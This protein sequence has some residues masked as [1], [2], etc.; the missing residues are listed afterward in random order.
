M[1]DLIVRGGRLQR[2][3]ALCLALLAACPL[4]APFSTL[5]L[6]A[7][8]GAGSA[9]DSPKIKTGHDA[10]VAGPVVVAAAPAGGR[11]SLARPAVRPLDSLHAQHAILR[12]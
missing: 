12:L 4:T 8:D 11:T 2:V 3:L 1:P 10:V 6:T 5:D 7:V 9:L